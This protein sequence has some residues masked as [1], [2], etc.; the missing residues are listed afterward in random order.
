[1]STINDILNN[2]VIISSRL[3]VTQDVS[4]G[5]KLNVYNDTKLMKRLYV[6]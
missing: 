3:Y 2:N 6:E 5:S 4:F 1:M